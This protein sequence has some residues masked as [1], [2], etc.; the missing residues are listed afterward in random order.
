MMNI[1]E[2]N[3]LFLK[4]YSIVD[5]PLYN[6]SLRVNL[7]ATL[8]VCSIQF[9]ESVRLLCLN[10]L[11]IGAC[12]TLRS[13]FESI[14]RSVW[15][16]HCAS[17][18][19]IDKLSKDLNHKSQQETKNIPLVNE[20]IKELEKVSAVSN[21]LVALKEFKDSSW[22][23]LN[24]FVHSGIHAIHWTKNEAPLHLI[25]QT[26]RSSNGIALLA[27]IQLG[28]LTGIPGIQSRII[29]ATLPYANCLPKRREGI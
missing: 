21:L 29:S 12:S 13:Q 18:N 23:P 15:A 27:Y 4:I 14:I 17:D 26:F 8:S 19:Q 24:S 7:S 10:R 6:N 2:T 9:S 3:E 11:L 1:N 28:I 5:Y 20:M 16:L 25:D 22:L